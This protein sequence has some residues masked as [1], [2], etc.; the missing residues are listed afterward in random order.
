VQY[1]RPWQVHGKEYSHDLDETAVAPGGAPDPA[2]VIAWD[3]VL[4]G[5]QD[6]LDYSLPAPPFSTS[7]NFQVDALGNSHDALFKSLLRMDINE[8]LFPDEAHLVFSFDDVAHTVIG[9]GLQQVAINSAGPILTS[10]GNLVGGAGEIT[11]ELAGAFHPPSK[12]GIWAT[13]AQINGMPV[14]RDLDG[15]ELWGPEPA[16]S[17]DSDK[18]SVD[19]DTSTAGGGIAAQSVWNYDTTGANL[20][21]SPYISHALVASVVRS[22]LDEPS[23]TDE[24]INLDALMVQDDNM[25]DTRFDPGDKILFSIRQIAATAGLPS[26]FVAT[27]SEIFWMDG[28][29]TVAAPVGGYLFHGGHLWDK[30][31]ALANLRTSVFVGDALTEAVLDLDALEAIGIPEPAGAMLLLV[32]LAALA[33]VHRQRSH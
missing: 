11:Y 8:V 33:G 12:Q 25:P 7:G 16:T 15:L 32:G 5:T 28:A 23:L 30:A 4:G 18:Y 17:D 1:A 2:Q 26:G 9:S 31:Y 10:G 24:Q 29:S 22:L 6:G 3:G 13:Q 20:G 21:S 27:G 19:V 14:P